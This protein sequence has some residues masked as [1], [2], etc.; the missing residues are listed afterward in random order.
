MFCNGLSILVELKIVDVKNNY[1]IVCLEEDVADE[2]RELASD[3][4]VFCFNDDY[5]PTTEGEMLEKFIDKFF[6]G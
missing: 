1:T 3:K 6:S 5:T 4:L 2:I